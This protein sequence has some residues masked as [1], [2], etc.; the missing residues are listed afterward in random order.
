MIFLWFP[1][2]FPGFS[3]GF[4][5]SPGPQ[6][7]IFAPSTDGPAPPSAADSGTADVTLPE[8][9]ALRSSRMAPVEE[10]EERGNSSDLGVEPGFNKQSTVDPK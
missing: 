1:F 3:Q 9:A 5:S 8:V 7:L 6:D 4:P 2:V 10:R